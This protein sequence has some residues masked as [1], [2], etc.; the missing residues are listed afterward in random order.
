MGRQERLSWLSTNGNQERHVPLLDKLPEVRAQLEEAL[1]NPAMA[2]LLDG[3][4]NGMYRDSL[5]QLGAHEKDIAIRSEVFRCRP[6]DLQKI[7][8][9]YGC[10]IAAKRLS[11]Q[12]GNGSNGNNNSS[13]ETSFLK[14]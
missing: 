1:T 14:E 5:R 7:E 3:E 13:I 10:E 8:V 4:L 2:S 6:L 12:K 9:A 11:V